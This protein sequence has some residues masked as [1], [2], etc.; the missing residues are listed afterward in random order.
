MDIEQII[1]ETK[2]VR[3]DIAIE[4]LSKHEHPN[5]LS[6]E[7][8]RKLL[9]GYKE[10]LCESPQIK[11]TLRSAITYAEHALSKIPEDPERNTGITRGQL[12]YY[13]GLFYERANSSSVDNLS[14]AYEHINKGVEDAIT[15]R[16]WSAIDE[17]TRARNQLIN[18]LEPTDPTT[19]QLRGAND[20]SNTARELDRTE[21]P[22]GSIISGLYFRA[23][24]LY[25]DASQ[26]FSDKKDSANILLIGYDCIKKSLEKTEQKFASSRKLT[27]AEFAYSS[28]L[29]TR[30]K[31]YRAEAI[32]IYED[33]RKNPNREIAFQATKKL[34]E[35]NRHF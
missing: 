8:V 3:T 16:D 18:K 32:K 7:L 33:L 12:R 6:V 25:R 10:G 30:D 9:F 1:R 20:N 13:L 31:K 19:W 4:I 34:K 27:T 5:G 15:Y 35:I 24:K 11:Q 14:T 17:R 26:S 23:A 21:C 2:I 28:F 29:V 22:Y